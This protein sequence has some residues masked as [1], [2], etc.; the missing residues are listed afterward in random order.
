VPDTES[1]MGRQSGVEGLE[2]HLETKT[3]GSR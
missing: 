2:Q 1:G 3:I